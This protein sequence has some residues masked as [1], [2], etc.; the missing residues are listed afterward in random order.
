MHRVVLGCEI[1]C[2][3]E[4]AVVLLLQFV[5]IVGYILELVVLHLLSKV[6]KVLQ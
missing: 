1:T 3:T 5:V 2:I 4:H 6:V